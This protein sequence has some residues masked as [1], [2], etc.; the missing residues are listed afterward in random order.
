MAREITAD[1][2]A[3][4]DRIAA[5]IYSKA[6]DT[7]VSEYEKI[8]TNGYEVLGGGVGR[9]VLDLGDGYVLK[10]AT[11]TNWEA[12]VV[13]KASSGLVQNRNEV[14]REEDIDRED[15]PE[16]FARVEAHH[17]QY[18][19][20]VQEKADP[21]GVPADRLVEMKMKLNDMTDDLCIFDIDSDNVGRTGDGSV[22]IDYG[23]WER[24]DDDRD[25]SAVV[26]TA[27]HFV[28]GMLSV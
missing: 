13:P 7:L 5:E 20:T 11:K 24:V 18:L 25:Y 15:L 8:D 28:E 1:E 9:V 21:G 14:R 19:W 23:W 17:E 4:F 10:C 27:R 22:I 16:W 3:T 2:R 6:A 12:N 26:E